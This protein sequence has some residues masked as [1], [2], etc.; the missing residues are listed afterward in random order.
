MAG[1]TFVAAYNADWSSITWPDT[2]TPTTQAGDRIVVLASCEES[3]GNP[4]STPTGNG[5]TF[6]LAQSF[7]TSNFCC[8]YAWTGT[9]SAGGTAWTLSV[10]KTGSGVWGFVALVFR[11]SDGFG[12]SN[13]GSGTSGGPSLGLTTTQADSAIVAISSDWNAADGAS[14]T[15][16]TVDGIT[17][18]LGN[19][20]EKNYF[21]DSIHY[22]TYAAL[23]NGASAAAGA[24]TVGLSAPTG[25]KWST[26]AVEVK[27]TASAQAPPRPPVIAPAQAAIQAST[28]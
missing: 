6:T 11:G 9:D 16:R 24:K 13:V 10:T 18:T 2:V 25:Q 27:G 28:W 17:P 15:W 23:W 26:V 1:P 19:G 14:R 4:I 8:V 5:V 12:A 3:S 7:T 21:R 22:A 20:L